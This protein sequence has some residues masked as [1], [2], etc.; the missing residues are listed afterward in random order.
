[1]R[2]AP[3]RSDDIER[4]LEPL[5][6]SADTDVDFVRPAQLCLEILTCRIYIVLIGVLGCIIAEERHGVEFPLSFCT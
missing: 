1:M 4:V 6:V 5:P 2:G 3:G